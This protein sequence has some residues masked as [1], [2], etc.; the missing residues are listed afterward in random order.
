M[1]SSRE[2]FGYLIVKS[3]NLNPYSFNLKSIDSK[4]NTTSVSSGNVEIV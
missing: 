4:K 1:S 3:L 2:R